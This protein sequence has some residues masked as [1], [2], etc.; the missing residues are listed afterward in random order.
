MAYTYSNFGYD[1]CTCLG[2]VTDKCECGNVCHKDP[3]YCDDCL[4]VVK[5]DAHE[6]LQAE[7]HCKLDELE[8]FITNL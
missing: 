1:G 3:D 2:E 8:P 6:E 7:I 4:V 5:Q